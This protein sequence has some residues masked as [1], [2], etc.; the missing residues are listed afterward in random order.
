MR[1]QIFLAVVFV[2][3]VLIS[4][5]A[6]ANVSKSKLSIAK[7]EAKLFYSNTGSF[8][9]NTIDNDKYLPLYNT[10]I[11]EGNA[12]GSSDTVL[13]VVKLKGI[14]R[15]YSNSDVKLIV[16][17]A[18][19]EKLNQIRRVAMLNEHGEAYVAFMVYDC[20]DEPIRITAELLGAG[21]HQIITKR[22]E[23]TGGE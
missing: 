13:I 15:E 12:G 7:V 23:F 3:I 8:S 19:S 20:T 10:I 11:G 1:F 2:A 16:K 9:D 5:V 22:I 14:P 4:M 6:S 17:N 21:Q 18:H